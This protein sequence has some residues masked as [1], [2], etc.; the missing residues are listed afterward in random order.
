MLHDPSC[1]LCLVYFMFLITSFVCGGFK[2]L[3]ASVCCHLPGG[4]LTSYSLLSLSL[5]SSLF[6]VFGWCFLQSDLLSPGLKQCSGYILHQH[7]VTPGCSIIDTALC[8]WQIKD[9]L[10]T[11]TISSLYNFQHVLSRVLAFHS[12]GWFSIMWVA[13]WLPS[14]FLILSSVCSCILLCKLWLVSPM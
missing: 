14:C 3:S 7:S 2:V 8:S 13:I 5:Y 6:L 4:F 9:S 10:W 12:S 1:C 11:F